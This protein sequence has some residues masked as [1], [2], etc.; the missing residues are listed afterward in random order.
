[1]ALEQGFFESVYEAAMVLALRE[2]G[3]RVERQVQIPVWFRGQQIGHEDVMR[4]IELFG[5]KVIPALKEDESSYGWSQR[6]YRSL[7]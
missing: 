3:V 1:M 5:T 7:R 6:S 2:A 4:S